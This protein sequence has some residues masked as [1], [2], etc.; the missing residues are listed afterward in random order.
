VISDADDIDE[1]EDWIEQEVLDE[2]SEEDFEEE[3]DDELFNLDEIM[4]GPL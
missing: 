4:C 3:D 2:E 1:V